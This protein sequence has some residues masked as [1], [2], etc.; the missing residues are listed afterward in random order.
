MKNVTLSLDEKLL[1]AARKY[2]AS[3]GMSFQSFLRELIRRAVKPHRSSEEDEF[4]RLVE[5]L[6]PDSGGWKWSRK[7]VYEDL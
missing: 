7:E 3:R 4:F 2:A 1:A 6:Q 5:E